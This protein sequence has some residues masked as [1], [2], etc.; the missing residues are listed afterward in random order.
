M[1]PPKNLFYF[2]GAAGQSPARSLSFVWANH[3]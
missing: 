2:S 1:S 3:Q